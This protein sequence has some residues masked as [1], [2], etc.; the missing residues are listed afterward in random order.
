MRK[1]ILTNERKNAKSMTNIPDTILTAPR[2]PTAAARSDEIVLRTYDLTKQYGQR[3]AVN[4]LNLEVRRGDIFGFLGPNGAGKT[5][6][7]RMALGLITPT[8]GSVE[9]LG[10]DIATYRAHILPRVGALVET[11]A[12]YLYMSGRDNL[13]AVASVLGGVPAGRIDAVLE[14]VGLRGRQ[15]DRVRT[16]SLGMKQ[17]LGVAIALLQDPDVLILDEPANGLDPAGIV[18]MR[19]LMHRLA[20]EGKTVFIS[21]HLLSEVQ[22]ICTRVAIINL[23]KLVTEA[24]VEELTGGHGEFSVVV[25]RANEALKLVQAQPWGQNAHLDAKG[26]LITQAPEGRGRNLN[27]FLTHAGFVPDTIAQ[28][29][30]DLEQVFLRLTNSGSGDVQ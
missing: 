23:G 12:L 7:I 11:P 26:T 16:Y 17:R 14:L 28:S 10:K 8:Q 20:T 9:I 2:V 19:D 5:T 27:L 15:R 29:A 30:E 24:S 3:L 18:E 21:S 1:Y 6:T 13:Q 22:Q 25:E 4:D